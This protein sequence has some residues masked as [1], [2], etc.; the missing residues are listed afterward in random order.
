M[1]QL[2]VMFMRNTEGTVGALCYPYIEY[3]L[4]PS[5][6][7]V[8]RKPKVDEDAQM[9]LNSMVSIWDITVMKGEFHGQHQIHSGLYKCVNTLS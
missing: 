2:N 8:L 5:V 7:L 6:S 1:T 4:N 9:A 3:G